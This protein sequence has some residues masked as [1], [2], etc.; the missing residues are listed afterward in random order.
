MQKNIIAVLTVGTSFTST[1]D[2]ATGRDKTTNY[3]VSDRN[4]T[5]LFLTDGKCEVKLYIPAV[6]THIG[7]FVTGI[8]AQ[9]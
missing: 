1:R 3:I 6:E 5:Y 9:A 7:N 8:R 2:F 4:K